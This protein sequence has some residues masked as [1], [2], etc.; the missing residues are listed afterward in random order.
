MSLIQFSQALPNL[1]QVRATSG[2]IERMLGAQVPEHWATLRSFEPRSAWDKD[3]VVQC[4]ALGLAF[5]LSSHLQLQEA[6][7]SPWQH[8]CMFLRASLSC[9]KTVAWH[10]NNPKSAGSTNDSHTAL[11]RCVFVCSS[12]GKRVKPWLQQHEGRAFANPHS[13]RR[14]A[15]WSCCEPSVYEPL[16]LCRSLGRFGSIPA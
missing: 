14:L 13:A 12:A 8:A 15:G 5:C 4:V 2:A 6:T 10:P 11:Q 16:N 9:Q 1:R 7:A 3:A